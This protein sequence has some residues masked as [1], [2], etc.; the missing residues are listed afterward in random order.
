MIKM[1][2]ASII[3]PTYN[4]KSNLT[5]FIEKINKILESKNNE[6]MLEF[7]F[8]D[9]GSEIPIN[10]DIKENEYIKII[11]ND[12]NYG[13]GY[14]IKKAVNSAKYDLIGIIDSDNSYDLNFLIKELKTFDENKI[15]MIVGKRKFNYNEGFLRKTY[16]FF[17]N[18]FSSMIFNFKIEDI[19]SGIRLFRKDLFLDNK[20]YFPDRFSITS[21]QTL[22]YIVKNKKLKYIETEYNKRPGKSKINLFLDPFNFIFLIL[23][24]FMLFA[25]TKFFTWL[26]LFFIFMSFLTGIFSFVIY[27]QIADITVLLLFLAGFNCILFGLLAESLRLK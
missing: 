12:R 10:K 21:T 4:E 24:I 1:T 23:K 5:S 19:N 22:T 17:L 14:S 3:I 11:S 16:R 15:D 18:K 2:S 20:K 26:G 7:L 8:V 27:S 25:P 9:D 6:L 13:Y